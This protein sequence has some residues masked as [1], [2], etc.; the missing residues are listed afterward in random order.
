LSFVQVAPRTVGGTSAL[1]VTLSRPEVHNAFNSEIISQV[2]ATFQ[3]IADDVMKGRPSAPRCVVLTGVDPSFSAGADLQWMRGMKDFSKEEQIIDSLNLFD[4]FNSIYSCPVPVI[5]RIN[6]S[7]IGGGAGLVAACDIAFTIANAT[8]GFTEV[9]LGLIPA[10]ISPFVVRKI[11]ATAAQ[12]YFL[13]G[14]KFTAEEAAHIGLISAPPTESAAHLDELVN[15]T[16][17]Q[18]GTSGPCAIQAA[19]SLLRTII[20]NDPQNFRDFVTAQIAALRV[21]PEGQEGLSAFLEKR[22]PAWLPRSD[23]RK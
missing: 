17:A 8:F 2:T 1:T 21:S 15:K 13:T 3:E 11:G 12:H 18:I 9:K 4:M 20:P 7:A 5:G 23:K 19:K 6:G 10:V 22:K 14:E 16:I